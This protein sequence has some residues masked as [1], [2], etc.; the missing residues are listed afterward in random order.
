V[1]LTSRPPFR[2]AIVSGLTTLLVAC[3]GASVA[4]APLATPAPAVVGA[5]AP[6]ESSSAIQRTLGNQTF[7]ATNANGSGT[8]PMFAA[9]PVVALHAGVNRV[10]VIVHGETRDAGTYY[11]DVAAAAGMAGASAATAFIVAPQF[12]NTSDVD[13][14]RNAAVL[15]STT[16]GWKVDEYSD[17]KDAEKPAQISA[18]DVLD[19]LIASFTNR[20][21]YPNL[22]TIVIAGHSGGAQLVGR[23]A[24]VGNGFAAA[25]S[26]G[27]DVR[28]VVASPSS[29]LYFDATRPSGS[30][31][32]AGN[33]GACPAF[34]SWRYGLTSAPRYVG[35]PNATALWHRYAGENVT[36]LSGSLDTDAHG[37]IDQSCGAEAEGVDRVDR[38]HKYYAYLTFLNG[39]TAV[40]S[41]YTV[42]GVGHNDLDMLTSAAAV[43]ALF[44]P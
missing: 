40:Q 34:D 1:A 14:S 26:G 12:L 43:T 44:G 11:N 41:T 10:V 30:S 35:S 24:I 3:G 29:F 22:Q 2:V 7:A 42:T 5:T 19:N 27:Y 13:E 18:F 25:V 21:N 4:T 36:Y 28:F 8:I 31:F 15:P 6:V 23:Y 39:G 38:A 37:S 9:T 33:A 32:A 17:G 16:L 20:S